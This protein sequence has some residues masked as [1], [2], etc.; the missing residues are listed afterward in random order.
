[1]QA[2]AGF[3]PLKSEHT[4]QSEL[5]GACHD[6][7]T[8]YLDA[9]GQVAGEF[10]EQM[11]YSE[12]ANSTHQGSQSCRDCHM[13]PAQGGVQIAATGGP[14]RTPFY[15]HAFVGGNA[16]M[17][18]VLQ[19]NSAALGVT[20]SDAHFETIINAARQQI[21]T[22]SAS[23]VLEGFVLQDGR[24]QGNALIQSRAG[25]KFPAGFP[26][27]RAWLHITVRDAGGTVIFESGAVDPDGRIRDNDND[28]D[29]ARFEPHYAVLTAPD[30]VQ[31]YE[32]IMQD[33]EEKVTTV[34][35][36]RR[37]HSQR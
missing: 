19:Q 36:P 27:R 24:L 13:Q 17:G 34:L 3:I 26:S 9:Q 4:G 33:T 2:A 8:P 1:M 25:H 6:L 23:L 18:Q 5:C 31:I 37:Q 20:A 7:R 10:P 35:L 15:Q 28:L 12:W 11:I 16:Y 32:L 21:E 22:Q 29:G 30:Q 14:Q